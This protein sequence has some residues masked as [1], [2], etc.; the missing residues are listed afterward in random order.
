MW[1]TLKRI[2]RCASGQMAIF[3]AIIFQVLFV[4]FAMIINIGLLVHD[5]INLQNSVD[6]AAYYAASKQ[7]EVLNAMAHVNYQIRQTY[8]LMAYRLRVV[9]GFGYNGHP[10]R[11]DYGGPLA[12]ALFPSVISGTPF[13]MA[14]QP[15]VCITHKGWRDFS[16]A[17]DNES[18]CQSAN[19]TVSQIPSSPVIFALNPLNAQLSNYIEQIKGQITE[20]C[21]RGGLANWRFAAIINYMYK[22]DIVRRKMAFLKFARNL[23]DDENGFMDLDGQPVRGGTASTLEK[24]LTSGNKRNLKEMS[25]FNSLA[26][27]IEN[28]RPLWISDLEIDPIVRYVLHTP[29][30]GS[31]CSNSIEVVSTMP[32]NV[33]TNDPDGALR[34]MIGEP[35]RGNIFH[36]TRGFEKNPW[37]MAY[38]G[39]SAKT[40][41][42]PPFAPFGSPVELKAVAFAKP[43][44]GRIGPWDTVSWER[45]SPTSNP[46]AAKVDPL[47]VPRSSPSNQPTGDL[48]KDS[49]FLPNYSK[50]PGDKFG[51]KSSLSMS[52]GRGLLNK[53]DVN[54][55]PYTNHYQTLKTLGSPQGDDLPFAEAVPNG[56]VLRQAELAAVSPD[57]FDAIYYSVEPQFYRYYVNRGPQSLGIG[58]G[59]PDDHGS[60]GGTSSIANAYVLLEASRSAFT[61]NNTIDYFFLTKKPSQL[62]TGWAQEQEADYSFPAN[63]FA[64]CSSIPE[65]NSN[66][67]P[68]PGDCIIGGRT[69]Y[70]V[71]IV[72]RDYLLS[73]EHSLGG[74][75]AGNGNIKNP[76]PSALWGGGN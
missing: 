9:G 44:G 71:K 53:D 75:G 58:A 65:P 66:E 23:S 41:S 12:E 33:E 61:I 15:A 10:A 43:F 55:R 51:L 8:K 27:K 21:K 46:G 13:L 39:V 37:Y 19:N 72:S 64:E 17:G 60:I 70:S 3:I 30:S 28:G 76:P 50:Y 16:D 52:M 68:T 74:V 57:I 26:T 69:G 11:L 34:S 2:I 22:K 54:L 32:P 14:D 24:N 5:K 47:A 38:V 56:G 40:F 63:K 6:L 18:L 49:I 35:P 42:K 20:T 67:P 7:A 4:F 59:A 25:I 73:Q 1:Q 36:S 29:G 31:G 48:A 62:L 45:E